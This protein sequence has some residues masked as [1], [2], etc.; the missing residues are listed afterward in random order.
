MLKKFLSVYLLLSACLYATDYECI[1]LYGDYRVV[2]EGTKNTANQVSTK[3]YSS[4]K[5]CNRDLENYLNGKKTPIAYE[6]IELYG[7]YRVVVEGTKNPANQVSS[8][9]YSSYKSCNR[10]LDNYLNGKKTPV[11]YECIELYGDFRVVLAGTKNPANQVSSKRYSNY[12]SCNRDLDNYLNGK[13]TPVE[14]ECIELY[15]D[16]RVVLAGTKN[17]A[18]QVSSKRYSNYKSCNRDLDNYLNGK[19]TPVA[20]ECIEL[21]GDYRVVLEG[22]KNPANQVSSLRYTSYGSCNKALNEYLSKQRQ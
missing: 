18:N 3:R 1:E 4:Y 8:K 9:R 11:E 15:G 13:K 20:Y 10:D 7:D 6:C 17:P 5:S 19:K 12:K 22:T 16:F 14:Y 2:I 21:Y